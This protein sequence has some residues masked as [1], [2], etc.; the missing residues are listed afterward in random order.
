VLILDSSADAVVVNPMRRMPLTLR[1]LVLV[2]LLAATVDMARATLACGPHAETC[3]EAAG[4]GYLG[5]AGV[6]LIV[7]YSLGLALWVARG[8]A[9]RGGGGSLL[10]TWLVGS[11]GVAA[12]CGGQALLAGATGQAAALGG[13][14][15]EL[16]AF[17]IAAGAVIALALR[18]APAAAELVGSMRPAAPRVRLALA[19]AQSFPS[20]AVLPPSS[21]RTPAT[22]GRAPPA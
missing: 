3:L 21:P 22:A 13:G 8:A 17:C 14:W 4:R 9:P 7:L 5:S 10:H 15:P 6:A 20:L 19:P 2:P 1:A 12:A 18:A 11:V 16:I